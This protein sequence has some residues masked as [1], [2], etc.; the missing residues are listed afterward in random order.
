MFKYN[1]SAVNK[2]KLLNIYLFWMIF[3][4]HLEKW[5][6]QTQQFP[7]ELMWLIV[8]AIIHCTVWYNFL[9]AVHIY[10][11]PL[12]YPDNRIVSTESTFLWSIHLYDPTLRL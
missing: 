5:S 10:V 1:V 6:L 2:E 9:F 11:L 12:I 8:S 4:S 7:A 3:C